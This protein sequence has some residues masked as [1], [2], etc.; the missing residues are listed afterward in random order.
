[1]VG[2]CRP[3]ESRGVLLA[4]VR[5]AI[6][7]RMVG[8]DL[9]LYPEWIPAKV[10]GDKQ[11]ASLEAQEWAI[12]LT[13]RACYVENRMHHS[14][15]HYFDRPPGVLCFLPDGQVRGRL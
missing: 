2:C 3:I 1:M 9:L 8:H 15:A 11:R 12:R 13:K 14:E 5:S 10:K 7:Y 6:P 4:Y